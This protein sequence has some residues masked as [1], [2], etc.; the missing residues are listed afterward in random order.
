MRSVIASFLVLLAIAGYAGD[1]PWLSVDTTTATLTVMQTGQPP[2]HYE[3]ISIGRNGTSTR[4]QRRDNHTPLGEYRVTHITHNSEFGIFIGIN[5]PNLHDAERGF[6]SGL[7]DD[8]AQRDIRQALRAG[9]RPPQETALGGYI[10]IHGIG[11]GDPGVHDAFNW[12]N[13][14]I[15]LTNEQMANLVTRVKPG[16]R[17]VIR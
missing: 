12:T 2:Q 8:A 5:Y 10:G 1:N 17:V 9:R 3:N 15:A 11:K 14:C 13:G 4:K 16:T 6:K 7:I